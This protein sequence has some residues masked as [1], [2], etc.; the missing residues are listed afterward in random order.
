MRRRSSGWKQIHQN[1]TDLLWGRVIKERDGWR[2]RRCPRSKAQGW[3]M[4]G[5]HLVGRRQPV[6]WMLSAGICLCALC[7]D[8]GHRNEKDFDGWVRLLIGPSEHDRLLILAK[9]SARRAPDEQI[10]RDML[11]AELKRLKAEVAA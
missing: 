9:G 10:V 8:W 6:R 11:R 3:A 5:A 2:C 4:H 7:H 1:A